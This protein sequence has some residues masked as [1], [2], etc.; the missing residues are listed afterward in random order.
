M[1]ARES[2][3][4][5]DSWGVH[6]IKDGLTRIAETT[7]GCATGDRARRFAPE[8]SAAGKIVAAKALSRSEEP[9]AAPWFLPPAG[10]SSRSA[11]PR[12][13]ALKGHRARSCSGFRPSLSE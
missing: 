10:D 9:K 11:G 12:R 8:S 7:R 1:I 5:R 13:H 6:D 2:F 3:T 4:R